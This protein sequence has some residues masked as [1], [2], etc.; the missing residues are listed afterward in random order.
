MA[1]VILTLVMMMTI[2]TLIRPISWTHFQSQIDRMMVTMMMMTTMATTT[3]TPCD[4]RV[5][6]YLSAGGGGF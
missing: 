2:F 1:M 3:T 4:R 5:A 6:A